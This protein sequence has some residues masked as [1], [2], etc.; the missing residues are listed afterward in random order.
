[1]AYR[2]SIL[3]GVKVRHLNS[4]MNNINNST[5]ASKGRQERSYAGE[6]CWGVMLG[7][8]AGEL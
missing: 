7:S 6:L 8:Y 4:F 3:E 1:M 2:F 5:F